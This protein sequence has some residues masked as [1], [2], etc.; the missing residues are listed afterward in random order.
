M[1]EGDNRKNMNVNI[2]IHRQD[3]GILLY[4][5]LESLFSKYYFRQNIMSFFFNVK[6]FYLTHYCEQNL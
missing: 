4:F 2:I 6:C 5:L 3:L 1:M